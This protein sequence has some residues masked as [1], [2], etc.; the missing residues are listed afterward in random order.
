MWKGPC[1]EVIYFESRTIWLW[2]IFPWSCPYTW[3]W[4][5]LRMGFFLF[6]FF[7]GEP[8]CVTSL[9]M[10]L[11]SSFCPSWG[12]ATCFFF[13]LC[14]KAVTHGVLDASRM[15][16]CITSALQSL[17]GWMRK[18]EGWPGARCKRR[19]N[20]APLHDCVDTMHRV[21][22]SYRITIISTGPLFFLTPAFLNGRDWL[23]RV[24]MGLK[25][26]KYFPLATF[27]GCVCKKKSNPIFTSVQSMGNRFMDLCVYKSIG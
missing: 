7:F 12:N 24:L 20:F 15:V 22:C 5:S 18:T 2:F 3:I 14:R 21:T 27:I 4:L 9:P 16:R 13:F 17:L 1:W 11:Y 26:V 23:G 10:C 25:A 6:L 8:S 19:C